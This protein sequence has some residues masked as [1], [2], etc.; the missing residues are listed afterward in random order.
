MQTLKNFDE[1]MTG[2][3]VS[4]LRCGKFI[5]EMIGNLVMVVHVNLTEFSRGRSVSGEVD[6]SP[7]GP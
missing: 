1:D 4:G 3:S 2:R 5:L 6:V 7:I